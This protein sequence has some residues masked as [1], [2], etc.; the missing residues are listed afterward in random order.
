MN[1]KFHKNAMQIKLQTNQGGIMSITKE[2][3]LDDYNELLNAI[4][5]ETESEDENSG[6]LFEEEIQDI[7]NTIKE[8]LISNYGYEES[9]LTDMNAEELIKEQNTAHESDTDIDPNED[10]DDGSHEYD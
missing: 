6:Y 9:E 5:N 2:Y 1:L 10:F 4:E 3:E 7:V 8:D